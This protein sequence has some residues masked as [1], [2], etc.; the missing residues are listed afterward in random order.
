MQ[1]L[2]RDGGPGAATG[3]EVAGEALDVGAA[4]P[5]QAQV[6]LLAPTRVLAQVKRVCLAGQAGVGRPGTR[7][8][9]SRSTLLNIGSAGMRAADGVVVVIRHLQG[10]AQPGGGAR[11]GASEWREPPGET[12]EHQRQV[13]VQAL[14]QTSSTRLDPVPSADYGRI[15]YQ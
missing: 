1:S 2:A 15:P 10:R 14:A 13:T 11:R 8:T 12:A 3:F 6:V 9:R 7:L 4:G 5:E